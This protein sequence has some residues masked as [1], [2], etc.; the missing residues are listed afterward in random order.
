MKR[1]VYSQL[2]AWK[3]DKADPLK[4]ENWKFYVIPTW[5]IWS[6]CGINSSITMTK[7][8]RLVRQ[9]NYM[10]LKA[11]IDKAIGSICNSMK[12]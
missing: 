1:Q 5:Y 3:N 4:I 11:D 10:D 6:E 9:S 7:V 2:L 8:Q 12:G